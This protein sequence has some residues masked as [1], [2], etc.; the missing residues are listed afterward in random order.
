MRNKKHALSFFIALGDY[1]RLKIF[2]KIIELSAMANIGDSPVVAPN[3]AKNLQQIFGLA[4]STISHHISVLAENNLIIEINKG[5]FTY[6]FPN[7]STINLVGD[8]LKTEIDPFH[9]SKIIKL[10]QYFLRHPS[11]NFDNAII[12]SLITFGAKA[13]K[14]TKDVSGLA[15]IYFKIKGFN[16]PFFLIIQK[17]FL[18]FWGLQK[19]QVLISP[20]IE[21][22]INHISISIKI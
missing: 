6:L 19:H 11:E 10:G 3:T 17:D 22:I 21:K 8:F 16:E 7:Y 20:I 18:T 12:D 1:S 13:I 14:P 2:L 9:N 5:K 4:K 15:K